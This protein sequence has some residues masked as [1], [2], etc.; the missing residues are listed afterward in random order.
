VGFGL[1]LAQYRLGIFTRGVPRELQAAAT[2]LDPTAE[3]F[4]WSAV[5]AEIERRGLLHDPN[6]FLFTS[7]WYHS[8]QLAF[9]LGD[10][11][12]VLCYSERMA[13]G[14]SQWSRPEQWVGHDGILVVLNDNPFESAMYQ[15]W[16]ET[17]EPLG[18]FDIGRAGS[19]VKRVRLYHCVHQTRPFPFAGPDAIAQPGDASPRALA[20]HD[21]DGLSTTPLSS[22]GARRR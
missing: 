3:L 12:P 8:G 7:R 4:G 10:H 19:P 11:T 16:F 6:T 22:P 13:Q 15:R 17:I 9:A 18:D 2:T 5:A 20:A 14:F 1:V 21:R